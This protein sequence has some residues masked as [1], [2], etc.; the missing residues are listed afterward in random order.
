MTPPVAGR[1]VTEALL[2]QGV[3]RATGNRRISA[4]SAYWR[5]LVKRAGVPASPWRGQSLSRQARARAGGRDK[6]SAALSKRFGRYRR[7]VGV[8]ERE[9]GRRHSRVDFH[10]WRR[11]FVTEARNAGADQAVVAAVVGHEVGNITYDVYAGGPS[12]ALLRV[13]VEAV[14]VPTLPPTP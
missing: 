13:C 4:A 6:R 10:S 12:E 14:R 7:A 3:D 9:D 5:W 8:H 2:R 1:F 11:W